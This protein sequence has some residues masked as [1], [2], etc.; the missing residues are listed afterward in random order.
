MTWEKTYGGASYEDLRG[1]TTL[2][3]VTVL[4]AANTSS[5]GAGKSDAWLLSV[6]STTGAVVGEQLAGGTG[7]DVAHNIAVDGTGQVVA[8]GY[9]GSSSD[10]AFSQWLIR[11]SATECG[12]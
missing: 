1:L 10:A 11:L 6:S 7:H 3:P 2:N 9:E 4:A 5:I 12:P 8:V